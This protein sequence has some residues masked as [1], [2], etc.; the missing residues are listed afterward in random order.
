METELLEVQ[1]K[2][3]RGKNHI[4]YRG[5]ILLTEGGVKLKNRSSRE[6]A[7]YLSLWI[8]KAQ[9]HWALS[10]LTQLHSHH[11]DCESPEIHSV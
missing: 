1:S 6:T 8:L 3:T 9:L 2:S 10:S 7:S 5:N 4:K 11:F